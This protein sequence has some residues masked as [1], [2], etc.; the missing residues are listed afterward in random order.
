MTYPYE[1]D[2]ET[3]LASRGVVYEAGNLKVQ[4]APCASTSSKPSSVVSMDGSTRPSWKVAW[5]SD[6][7]STTA[8]RSIARSVRLEVR[9][10]TPQAGRAE[11]ARAARLVN[12]RGHVLALVFPLG[13]NPELARILDVIESVFG[14]SRLTG[15]DAELPISS[16]HS[17]RGCAE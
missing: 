12:G 15:R 1:A 3:C 9:I 11:A 2:L 10:S 7:C 14:A 13:L 6:R 16:D 17:W 8:R 4:H 5:C